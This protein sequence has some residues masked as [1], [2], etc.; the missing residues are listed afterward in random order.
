MKINNFKQTYKTL[1]IIFASLKRRGKGYITAKVVQSV[2]NPLMRLLYILI[3]GMIINEPTSGKQPAKIA[4]LVL[5]IV[6][7]SLLERVFNTKWN[8]LTLKKNR[9]CG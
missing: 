1:K 8:Q 5:I 3:P 7:V 6:F 9:S 2:V 4:V